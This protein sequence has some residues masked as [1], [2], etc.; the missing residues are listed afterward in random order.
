M[1][2]EKAGGN[3]PHAIV[4]KAS[5]AQFAHARIDDGVSG[6]AALPGFQIIGRVAPWKGLEFLDQTSVLNLR[7]MEQQLIGKFAPAYFGEKFIAIGGRN[8]AGFLGGKGSGDKAA[9]A[10]FA[11]P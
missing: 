6:F 9:W 11:P 3:H 8:G 1:F 5:A 10:D 4:H 2:D 7:I